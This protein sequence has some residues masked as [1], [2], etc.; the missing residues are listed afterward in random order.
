MN[1]AKFFEYSDKKNVFIDATNRRV[2]GTQK[3]S[4]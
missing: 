3:T 4:P 1:I 2:H